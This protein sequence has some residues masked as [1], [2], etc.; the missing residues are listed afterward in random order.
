MYELMD[1]WVDGW[2]YV[3]RTMIGWTEIIDGSGE[4]KGRER[5]EDEDETDD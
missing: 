3:S 2:M 4:Q 1:G 5:K